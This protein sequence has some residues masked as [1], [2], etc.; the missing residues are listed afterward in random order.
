[1][2]ETALHNTAPLSRKEVKIKTS[3]RSYVK[4][5][6]HKKGLVGPKMSARDA[7]SLETLSHTTTMNPENFVVLLT[8]SY[9]TN[10]L[11]E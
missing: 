11:I 4:S 8:V 7:Q 2:K 5:S 6:L 1:M 9:G 3:L 10:L